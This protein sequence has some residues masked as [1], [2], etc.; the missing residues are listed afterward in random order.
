M[1]EKDVVFAPWERRDLPKHWLSLP[2]ARRQRR[3]GRRADGAR[4]SRK[5]RDQ[6]LPQFGRMSEDS[7]PDFEKTFLGK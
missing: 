3:R 7:I 6:L 4:L 2:G 5:D 1:R